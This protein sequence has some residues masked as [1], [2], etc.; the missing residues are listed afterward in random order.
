[1]LF[2]EYDY[3]KNNLEENCNYNYYI[4]II[5][6]LL[7]NYYNDK[8]VPVINLQGLDTKSRTETRTNYINVTVLLC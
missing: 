2:Y 8:I 4:I 1:M 5:I 3:E 6:V 7:Y